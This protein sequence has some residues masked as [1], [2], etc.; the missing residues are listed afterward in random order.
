MTSAA[1]YSVAA[2]KRVGTVAGRGR[3]GPALTCPQANGLCWGSWDRS[4][5]EVREVVVAAGDV[6]ADD[7][8]A[9][10][11]GLVVMG[12]RR[13]HQEGADWVFPGG[14]VPFIGGVLKHSK[15]KP[16]G[17]R[18]LRRCDYCEAFND[19]V[20]EPIGASGGEHGLECGERPVVVELRG[21][22][23]GRE[24]AGLKWMLLGIVANGI[25]PP[26]P[27]VANAL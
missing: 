14:V 25:A 1:L 17:R 8:S 27:Q 20:S 22:K 24:D 9:V 16:R 23:R 15:D 18:W 26:V 5:G 7:C 10:V 21:R 13:G 2:R 3:C 6:V 4:L 11:A 12:V 19:V